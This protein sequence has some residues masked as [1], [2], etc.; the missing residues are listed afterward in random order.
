MFSNWSCQVL[1]NQC[2]SKC[3]TGWES[4]SSFTMVSIGTL[5]ATKW[6]LAMGL[7]NYPLTVSPPPLRHKQLLSIRILCMASMLHASRGELVCTVGHHYCHRQLRQL[8]LSIMR[9]S[10]WQLRQLT[11]SS[12][13]C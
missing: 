7:T 5:P 12:M 8:T 2:S 11:I 6:Y 9:Y 13:G 10:H 4:F 1:A 3:H